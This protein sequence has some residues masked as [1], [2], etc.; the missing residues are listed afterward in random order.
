MSRMSG[1]AGVRQSEEGSLSHFTDL[2]TVAVLALHSSDYPRH[3]AICTGL[4]VEAEAARANPA[5]H[6]EE[7]PSGLSI[8]LPS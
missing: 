2:Q 3:C 5:S 1:D 8:S 6:V 7:C 4:P